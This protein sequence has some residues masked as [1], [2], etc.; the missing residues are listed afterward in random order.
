MME[1]HV[2]IPQMIAS[3]MA[4]VFLLAG[5]GSLLNVIATRLARA[6]DRWRLLG[7]HEG[8][9]EFE[10]EREALFGRIAY[11]N[12]ATTL[13]VGSALC[14]CAVVVLVFLNPLTQI[15]VGKAAG[16][17]FIVAMLLLAGGLLAFLAEIRLAL[18]TPLGRPVQPK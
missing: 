17:V 16:W 13:C 12:W 3:A 2:V 1:T 9:P 11:A 14:V 18:R 15:D 5:I 8:E 4:P 10:A 7:H 6:V